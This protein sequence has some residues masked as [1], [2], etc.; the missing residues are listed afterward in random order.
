MVGKGSAAGKGAQAGA[1]TIGASV[2]LASSFMEPGPG[3]GLPAAPYG[4][5]RPMLSHEGPRVARGALCAAVRGLREFFRPPL[6]DCGPGR[7]A[8]R[9]ETARGLL[10]RGSRGV[11]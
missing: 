10:G 8:R 5:D 1:F 2:A 7:E 9:R 3:C 11:A 4:C 6:V